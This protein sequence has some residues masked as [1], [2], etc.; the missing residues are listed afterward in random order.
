ML[1]ATAMP[2]ALADDRFAR[3]YAAL[4]ARHLATL[5]FPEVRRALEALSGV[6][7]RGRDRLRRGADLDGAGKRAAFALFYAPIHFLTARGIAR[8]RLAGERAPRRIVD[9]GCGT[10]AVGAALAIE[11]GE[12]VGIDGVDRNA[13]ALAEAR[14][15]FEQLGVSGRTRAGDLVRHRVDPAGA[16]IVLGWAVNELE[17][18]E[19]TRLLATIDRWRR[20]GADVLVIEPIA[21]GPSPWWEDWRAW[22]EARGGRAGE[23]RFR[24]E[25]PER[26]RLLDRAAGMDHRELTARTLL[27][28]PGSA[29]PPPEPA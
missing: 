20:F 13:W 24:V 25:L 19:R 18:S 23:S 15:N 1:P 22:F 14:W 26:L 6:Y 8:E 12:G 17:D 28:P 10:G 2:D 21:R 9:L 27:L 4:E 29:S 5:T 7:V 16:R 11:S 3:W